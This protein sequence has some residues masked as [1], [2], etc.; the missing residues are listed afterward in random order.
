MSKLTAKYTENLL[1]G[2][3]C[4]NYLNN[5]FC[6]KKNKK[7]YETCFK[8]KEY[9]DHESVLQVVRLVYCDMIKGQILSE[10]SI[11]R[12]KDSVFCIK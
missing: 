10:F 6:N 4:S 7:L 2:K 3:E 12:N 9:S 1:S 8:W 5:V 11:K